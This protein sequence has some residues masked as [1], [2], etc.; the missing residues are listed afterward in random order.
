MSAVVPDYTERIWRYQDN[1]PNMRWTEGGDYTERIWRYQ[2][3]LTVPPGLTVGDYTERIWRYQDNAL[4]N[5]VRVMDLVRLYREDLAVSGQHIPR[6]QQT[7]GRRL[8]REDLAVSGQLEQVCEGS[9]TFALII[10][11]GFGGIRTTNMMS[12]YIVEGA[13]IPRG[14]GGI[15]TT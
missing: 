3:N 15:R 10:P 11:R 2:D 4:V 8:Y 5:I 7:D 1:S 6:C 14:F 12:R 13:I 9:W